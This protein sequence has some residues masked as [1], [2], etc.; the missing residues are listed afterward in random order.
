MIR[1][2]L[3]SDPYPKKITDIDMILSLSVCI[4]SVCIHKERHIHIYVHEHKNRPCSSVVGLQ[5]LNE[6]HE[7]PSN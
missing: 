6:G 3:L 4:R 2:R 5:L 7:H 1:I